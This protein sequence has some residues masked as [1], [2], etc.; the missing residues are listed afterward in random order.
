MKTIPARSVIDFPT[1]QKLNDLRNSILEN[2]Y[3]IEF[4][5][6]FNRFF[7]SSEI[8]ALCPN[9]LDKKTIDSNAILRNLID[10]SFSGQRNIT[11][12]KNHSLNS[13]EV[14]EKIPPMLMNV[15]FSTTNEPES[16][17]YKEWLKMNSLPN[18]WKKFS[19]NRVSLINVGGKNAEFKSWEDFGIKDL[20]LSS[21]VIFDP[22]LFTE[23][24]LIQ[25]NIAKLINGLVDFGRLTT[26]IKI[27]FVVGG[28]VNKRFSPADFISKRYQEVKDLLEGNFSDKVEFSIVFLQNSFF[29][30]RCIL[31]NYFYMIAGKGFNFFTSKGKID[32]KTH[33]TVTV[34]YLSDLNS[35]KEFKK[36]VDDNCS[37]IFDTSKILDIKGNWEDNEIIQFARK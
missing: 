9:E 28:D 12:D 25:E 16:I 23:K 37:L 35:I 13:P 8:L 22:Y 26:P 1:I 15:L 10:R 14:L 27:L 4:F 31:S 20:P 7:Y 18:S 21:L 30:E 36:L 17:H 6:E 24:E 32:Q 3:L 29:H 34:K 19:N 11:L 2:S 5:A 33:N